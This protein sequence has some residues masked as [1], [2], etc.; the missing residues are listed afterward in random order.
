M[1]QSAESAG[2]FNWFAARQKQR[3][4]AVLQRAGN[5]HAGANPGADIPGNFFVA[6]PALAKILYHIENNADCCLGMLRVRHWKSKESDH[7]FP[8]SGVQK[9]VFFGEVFS[10]LANKSRRG[11][12]EGG[13][14]RIFRECKCAT[15]D[16]ARGEFVAEVAHHNAYVVRFRLSIE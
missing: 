7:A 13:R 16:S 3:A 6:F 4:L 11:F 15:A 8:V 5:Y 10:G 9:S 2:Q 12:S 1:V 14:L